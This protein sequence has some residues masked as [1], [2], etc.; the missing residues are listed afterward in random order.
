MNYTKDFARY[1]IS[2]QDNISEDQKN[3][4]LNF[5][6]EAEITDIKRLLYTGYVAEWGGPSFKYKGDSLA[7]L[8]KNTAR[9]KN[10][11]SEYSYKVKQ[12]LQK[13]IAKIEKRHVGADRTMKIAKAKKDAAGL[14]ADAKKDMAT[15]TKK[16][17]ANK[18]ALMNKAKAAGI[19]PGDMVKSMK[20]GQDSV[21]KWA[22]PSAKKTV[23]KKVVAKVDPNVVAKK[24][25]SALPTLAVAAAVAAA[26]YAVYKRYLSRAA[27]ACAG[28]GGDEKTLCM[29]NYK[30]AATQQRMANMK[31]NMSKCQQT[32]DPRHC[33]G[34]IKQTIDHLKSKL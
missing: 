1:Y 10:E 17:N 21:K 23:A 6:N 15:A 13:W 32:G 34:K 5:V 19:S 27:Q 16:L 4:L 22:D 12:K 28:K 11:F 26:S 33:Q 18:I 20:S 24:G 30:R 29:Q 31:R 3:E 9:N 7:A 8:Q 14:I 25:G 2:Y